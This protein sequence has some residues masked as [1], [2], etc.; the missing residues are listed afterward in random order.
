[1]NDIIELPFRVVLVRVL[2]CADSVSGFIG[3][4]LLAAGFSLAVPGLSSFT[5]WVVIYFRYYA[6]WV[7]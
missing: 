5:I 4:L 7:I 3:A 6:D 1:M 2:R